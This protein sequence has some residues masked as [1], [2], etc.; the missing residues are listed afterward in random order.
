MEMK[1]AADAGI[2]V[3]VWYEGW[4]DNLS[5][6]VLDHSRGVIDDRTKAMKTLLSFTDGTDAFN[7]IRKDE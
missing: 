1:E 7:F 3:I 5:P 4:R 6:W 2:P